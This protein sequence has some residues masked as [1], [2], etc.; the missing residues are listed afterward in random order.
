MVKLEPITPCAG[1]LPI[2]V[3]A[4]NLSE[5][6]PD[7]LTLLSTY[8]GTEK[9]LGAALLAEHGMRLAAPNRST[10]KADA[11]CVWFGHGQ[12]MLVGPKP[13]KTLAKS[14]AVVDQSDSWAIVH[15]QGA[16]A[17]DVLARLTTID[18]RPPVFKRGHTARTELRHMMVS[19]TRVGASAFEIMAFASMAGTLV[20]EVQDAMESVAAQG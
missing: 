18:L 10:T 2:T 1:L 5:V 6:S 19:I 17:A 13:A 4:C 15:L 11:K 16:G 9:K 20:R 14:A 8:K 3:G 7:N 12:V